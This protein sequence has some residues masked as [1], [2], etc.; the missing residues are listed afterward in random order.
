LDLTLERGDSPFEFVSEGTQLGFDA[1]NAR[2]KIPES[3]IDPIESRS[4]LRT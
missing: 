3:T 1:F 4:H 2:F